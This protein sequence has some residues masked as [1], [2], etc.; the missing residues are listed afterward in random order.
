MKE[1]K[2]VLDKET[3]KSMKT[4]Y[5]SIDKP[6]M[7]WHDSA[8]KD[9]EISDDNFYDYFMSEI[10]KYPSDTILLDLLGQKGFTKNDIE[11]EVKKHIK[12]FTNLGIKSGDVV[13]FMMLNTPEVIFMFL[14]LNKMGA[15]ANLIKFDESPDRINYMLNLTNSK[16]FFVTDVPPIIMNVIK[17]LNM[18]NGLERVIT[19]PVMES[20]ITSELKGNEI[21]NRIDDLVY[22][23][24][25]EYDPEIEKKE[26]LELDQ[27]QKELRLEDNNSKMISYAKYKDLYLKKTPVKLLHKGTD[28]TTLIVYTGGS[29]GDAKG[30]ELTNKNLVAMVHGLKYSNY[31]FTYGKTSMNILPPA[32]AYYLNAT[33]GLMVC[34]VRVTQIPAFEIEKYPELIDMYKPNIIYSGPILLKLM[35]IS[36]YNFNYLTNPVSGG[37]KLLVNEELMIN[38]SFKQKGTKP[39]QQGYGSSEV[40]AVATCN[41]AIG[42]KIGSLGIPMIDVDVSIFEYQ[43]DK[44]IPY[45]KN[46]EGEICI[47]GPTLMKGYLNNSAATDYVKRYHNDGKYW[48]HT[49]DIGVM[50]EDG[51]IFHKGRYKRML[52]RNGQKLWLSALEDEVMKTGLVKDCCAVK[53]SDEVEREVPVLHLVLSNSEDVSQIYMLDNYLKENCPPTYLPKYYVVREYIPVTEV[54]NKKDFK[55]LEKED[56]LDDSIYTKSGKIIKSIQKVKKLD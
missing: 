34:G 30:V 16:Y 32:I 6:W 13:S 14:A 23:T 56:I 10:E 4:G 37:D 47:S 8:Y 48:L 29:T 9:L 26:F 44:E 21:K 40:T 33:C 5:A 1:E 35:A 54:N 49:D 36:P 45:G 18:D 55:A 43:T 51:F 53:M 25:K 39:V 2:Y 50:D 31:G 28:K 11:N 3:S 27:L 22:T 7:K 41:P 19:I 12:M 38:E 24:H 46:M 20:I 17:V 15:I 42:S 52:T